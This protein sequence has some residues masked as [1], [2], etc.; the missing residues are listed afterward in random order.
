MGRRKKTDAKDKKCII[1]MNEDELELLNGLSIETGMTKA[2][3]IRKGLR[4]VYNLHNFSEN[5]CIYKNDFRRFSV[6]TKM[7]FW[8]F[9]VVKSDHLAIFGQK[10]AIFVH[11]EILRLFLYI[12]KLAT[13]CGFLATF[14]NE[15]GQQK[16]R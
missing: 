8:P 5:W 2:D 1:R 7:I 11:T 10:S 15:N 6:Y 3:I 16:T 4:M 13:F 12:R 9:L 14:K